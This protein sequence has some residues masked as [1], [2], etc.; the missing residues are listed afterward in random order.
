MLEQSPENLGLSLARSPHEGS[1][2]L[3]VTAVGVTA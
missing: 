1:A 2:A 3:C